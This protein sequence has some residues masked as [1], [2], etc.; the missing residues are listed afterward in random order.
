MIFIINVFLMSSFCTVTHIY[1]LECWLQI[2]LIPSVDG[3]LYVS[4]L[5]VQPFP[6]LKKRLL[7]RYSRKQGTHS[8]S[9][10]ESGVSGLRLN[11]QTETASHL[12]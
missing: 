5:S 6:S 10:P 8:C 1:S 12:P 2:S 7:A 11:P 4:A 3:A 9:E